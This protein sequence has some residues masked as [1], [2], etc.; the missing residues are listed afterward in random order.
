MYKTCAHIDLFQLLHTV[1]ACIIAHTV[2]H[3]MIK[4]SIFVLFYLFL[5]L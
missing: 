4:L 3:L 1:Y 5:Y 2:M